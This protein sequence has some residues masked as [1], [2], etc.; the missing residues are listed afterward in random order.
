MNTDEIVLPDEL[1]PDF[2]GV[3][4]FVDIQRQFIA[5][6][7]AI[8]LEHK[9]FFEGKCFDITALELYLKLHKQRNVWWDAATDDDDNAEE[10]Y[11]RGTWYVRN[12]KGPSLLPI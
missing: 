6:A 10:Q 1:L 8:I 7:R 5:S 4:N 9:L 2:S 3:K 12:K 11:N